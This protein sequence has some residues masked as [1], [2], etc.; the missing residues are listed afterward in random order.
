MLVISSGS[1]YGAVALG[2]RY[3]ETISI[4][5]LAIINV[6]FLFG[7]IHQLKI[8]FF[9]CC[10]IGCILYVYAIV[11]LIIERDKIKET[12][13]RIFTPGFVIFIIFA[14]SF[15]YIIKGKLGNQWDEF[16]HW[17]DIVKVMTTID[18]FGTNPEAHSMFQSYP[19]AMTLFQY[20]CEKIWLLQTGTRENFS[21]WR[22]Y[23]A[24]QILSGAIVLPFLSKLKFAKK[25]IIKWVGYLSICFLLPIVFYEDYYV[26]IYID[27]FLGLLTGVGL[28]N[29]LFE[30]KKD[31]IYYLKQYLIISTLVITKDVG[32]A[33]AIF[34]L[35][36]QVLDRI[37]DISERESSIAPKDIICFILGVVAL[38]MPKLLW[39]WEIIKRGADI[40][41][42]TQ[43]DWTILWNVIR[44]R[45]YSYRATVMSS[46]ITSLSTKYIE[47]GYT[48]IHLNYFAIQIINIVLL[49]M[50][51]DYWTKKGHIASVKKWTYIISI[52]VLQIAYVCGMCIIY[53]FNFS[54]YEATNLASFSRYLNIVFLAI[55]FSVCLLYMEIISQCINYEKIKFFSI[56]LILCILLS[57]K[58][59]NVTDLFTKYYVQK[60]IFERNMYVPLVEKI[61]NVCEDD[62]HIYYISQGDHGYDRL[63]MAFCVRPKWIS[64][65]SSIGSAFTEDDIWTVELT[66]DEWLTILSEED[67]DYVAIHKLNDAFYEYYS[68]LF[69]DVTDIKEDCLYSFDRSNNK[70]RLVK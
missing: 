47:I 8:G 63:V 36:L 10:V 4:C 68:E 44:H 30:A 65:N 13:T 55:V 3:E 50:A 53:M 28:A 23:F 6:L 62:A 61:E 26:S 7:C 40:S 52:G 41:F 60:S 12:I 43:I 2:R 51:F 27:S 59:H 38:I 17:L 69:D 32:I 66:T 57:V 64:G 70:L 5:C 24:Y 15:A 20:L 14:I 22:A 48:G 29:V 16:S 37:Y 67:Y 56:L 19:P 54:E 9:V 25:D 34:L 35:I 49:Y 42:K 39:N 45:D 33:F 18:D 31:F 21:E 58:S 46:F 1:I 11:R